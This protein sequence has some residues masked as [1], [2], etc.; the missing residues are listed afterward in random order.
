VIIDREMMFAAGSIAIQADTP[1]P[2][3]GAPRWRLDRAR[4]QGTSR[5]WAPL[6][7]VQKDTQP[8]GID[9]ALLPAPDADDGG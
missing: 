3:T 8:I 6:A 5:P 4:E 1:D 7:P 2:K 9:P